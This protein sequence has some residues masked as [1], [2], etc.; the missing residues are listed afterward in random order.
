M[1]LLLNQAID[2]LS[3]TSCTRLTGSDFKQPVSHN[4][5][6]HL[7]II[8]PDMWMVAQTKQNYAHADLLV[9]GWNPLSSALLTRQAIAV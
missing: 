3:V 8:P 7:Q 6:I 2:G 5:I 9:G 4:F 1:N